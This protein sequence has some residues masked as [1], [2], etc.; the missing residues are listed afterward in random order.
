MTSIKTGLLSLVAVMA[1]ALVGPAAASATNVW[2]HNGAPL[3]EH[4]EMGLE[5]SHILTTAAGGLICEAEAT[6]TAEPGSTGQVTNY[7]TRKCMG[8]FGELAGCTVVRTEQRA[9]WHVHVNTGDLTSTE[10]ALVRT[11]NDACPVK[12]LETNIPELTMTL[13]EPSEISEIEYS[14]S[15][16]ASINGGPPAEYEEFGSWFVTPAGTYG[17]G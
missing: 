9:P 14:G 10:V 13:V 6:L 7:T 11:F 4:V 2:Q 12:R 1:L 15:G 3:G 17:I 5:G 8:L 16:E